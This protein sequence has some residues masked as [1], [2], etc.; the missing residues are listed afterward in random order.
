M[1]CIKCRHKNPATVTYCQKCG[2]KLD[3]TADDITSGLVQKAQ[4]ERIETTEHYAKQS[5][6]FAI[7]LFVAAF[8]VFIMSGGAPAAEEIHVVPSITSGA[9]YVAIDYRFDPP[10]ERATCPLKVK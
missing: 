3:F 8:T 6:F 9:R 7:L 1:N 10:L 4:E 5:L 2:M